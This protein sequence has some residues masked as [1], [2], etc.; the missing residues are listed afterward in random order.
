M[1]DAG[2][3]LLSSG[4]SEYERAV[5]EGQSVGRVRP[6]V[7]LRNNTL[8]RLRGTNVVFARVTADRIR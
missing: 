4:R 7:F 3:L 1:L 6:V 2:E 5:R 8:Y